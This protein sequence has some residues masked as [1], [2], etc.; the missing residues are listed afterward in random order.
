VTSRIESYRARRK[1]PPRERSLSLDFERAVNRAVGSIESPVA[2]DSSVVREQWPIAGS[3]DQGAMQQQASQISIHDSTLRENVRPE[4]GDELAAGDLQPAEGD[5]LA[6]GDSNIIE[7]PRPPLVVMPPSVEEL[8][9]P[10]ID[11]PRILDAPEAVETAEAP[12]G[13]IQ[14][15]PEEDAPAV[16]FEL[17][18]VVAAMSQRVFAGLA[19]VLVVALASTI[20]L[21][22]VAR[23]GATLPPGKAGPLLLSAAPLLFWAVYE[24][25]F[26]VHSGATPGMKI[27]R[28]QLVSFEGGPAHRRVR[29]G[30]ALAMVLS[31]LSLGLGLLWALL[32]EDTLCW[33]D[34]ISRS[35]LI[36]TWS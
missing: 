19:D 14:L 24:Y 5:W 20:F 13:G 28:L 16:E 1:R 27:A 30:R 4:T 2:G 32:D 34:R 9:E 26:L 6:T 18:L 36:S 22:I 8:A 21:V 12:L 3:E 11:K 35:Y 33:H 7:F 29:R 15:E 25:L 31:C 17:P 23:L 10:V